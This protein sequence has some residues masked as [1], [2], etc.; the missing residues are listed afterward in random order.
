MNDA[1][2]RFLDPRPLPARATRAAL[3]PGAAIGLGEWRVSVAGAPVAQ[4]SA[5]TPWPTGLYVRRLARAR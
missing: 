3:G 4:A 1:K 2:R 5:N